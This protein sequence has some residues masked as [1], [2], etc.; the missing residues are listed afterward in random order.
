MLQLSLVKEKTGMS[1]NLCRG[2]GRSGGWRWHRAVVTACHGYTELV[3]QGLSSKLLPGPCRASVERSPSLGSFP[4]SPPP[5]ERERRAVH[6][7]PAALLPGADLSSLCSCL[8]ARPTTRWQARTLPLSSPLPVLQRPA[9]LKLQA[10]EGMSQKMMSITNYSTS[11]VLPHGCAG[12]AARPAPCSPLR[13]PRGAE[14]PLPA[15]GGGFAFLALPRLPDRR[16]LSHLLW[17]QLRAGM[18]KAVA[19][20]TRPRGTYK[21]EYFLTN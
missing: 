18:G 11:W 14:A 4:P 1:K 19:T 13:A 6:R 10:G 16:E 12:A 20:C 9:Y 17:H 3:R 2:K 5:P 8:P 15:G 7:L 21:T